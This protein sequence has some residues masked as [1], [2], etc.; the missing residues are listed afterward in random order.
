[1]DNKLAF[2]NR[3]YCHFNDKPIATNSQKLVYLLLN[4][5]LPDANLH[6]MYWIPSYPAP[7]LGDLMTELGMDTIQWCCDRLGA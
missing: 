1:M 6:S 7:V 4:G 5:K 2:M 3:V